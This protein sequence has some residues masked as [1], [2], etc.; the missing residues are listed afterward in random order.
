MYSHEVAVDYKYMDELRQMVKQYGV[1]DPIPGVLKSLPMGEPA[2]W[3]FEEQKP[4]MEV[5]W[6]KESLSHEK[7]TWD[8]YSSLRFGEPNP[9]SEQLLE[10][11]FNLTE[12]YAKKAETKFS[13]R[14]S[15]RK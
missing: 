12:T 13:H 2:Y 9:G 6:R 3:E 14:T 15:P 8:R 5:Q 4:Q 1:L 7:F 11:F 10:F